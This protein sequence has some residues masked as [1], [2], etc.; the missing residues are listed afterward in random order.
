MIGERLDK[1]RTANNNSLPEH[2]LFYRD[3]VSE[4]QYGMVV[5]DEIPLIKAGSRAAGARGGKGN[6]WCPKITLLVV[7][8]R[9]HTR[10]FPKLAKNDKYN[11]NLQSGL[12]IDSGIITP[13][14]F[15]FYLQSH[16]SALGTARSAHY[17]VI[18]NES[19]YTTESIQE[20]V[21]KS[22]PQLCTALLTKNLDEHY[23]LHRF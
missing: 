10:F 14:H 4:S 5:N 3:G 21:S 15:S 19:N 23:L 11:N 2:I 17:I 22:F 8:K 12:V 7:G 13:N 6:S 20:T 16:D 18:I 9:H 1:Y